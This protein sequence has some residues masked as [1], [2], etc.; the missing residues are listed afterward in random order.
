MLPI[1][2]VLLSTYN[3][4]KFLEQ[5]IRSILNQKDV[6]VRILI[7]DDGSS[8]NTINLIKKIDDKRIKIME[9]EN[10]GATESFFELIR[11]SG[12]SDYYS[13][14]D[15]DDVWDSDKL[16]TG[17]ESIKDYNIPAIYSS[18]TRLVDADLKYISVPKLN[19]KTELTSAL[20]KN[21]VAGCTAVFNK[22]LMMLLRQCQK[23]V[24]PFHDWWINIVSLSVGGVSIYDSIPH[25]S[26]RQHEGNVVGAA[27]SKVMVWINRAHKFRSNIYRRDLMAKCV[28]ENYASNISENNKKILSLV[29]DGRR[30]PI[31]LI[32]SDIFHTDSK[33]DDFA[34]YICVLLKRI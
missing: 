1:V 33:I 21:Y 3:G 26:Y 34:F 30:N 4:E 8:D 27:K 11:L 7:R 14:A 17:I 5:Q 16:I 32:K 10:I 29:A 24:A 15:Q 12:D 13:F 25:M 28:L 22:K 20:V 23:P 19:P 6:E 9:G 2:Q 18:T 31:K